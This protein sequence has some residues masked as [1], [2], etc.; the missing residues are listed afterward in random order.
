ML[1]A[2]GSITAAADQIELLDRVGAQ[3]AE[4]V[5]GL[6]EHKAKLAELRAQLI[7]DRKTAADGRLGQGAREGEGRG[8]A[9][10]SARPCSTASAE[11]SRGS[12]A[13]RRQRKA[14]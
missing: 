8:P 2:S 13:P 1:I 10:T 6:R 9:R 12:F 11:S 14:A 5:S 3:D 4:V 7:E